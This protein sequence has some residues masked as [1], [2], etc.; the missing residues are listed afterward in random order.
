MGSND[1]QPQAAGDDRNVFHANCHQFRAAQCAD[2]AKQQQRTVAPA[3]GGVVAGGENLAQHRQGERRGLAHGATAGAH[4][5][6]QRSL[7]VAVRRVPCQVV[8][9]VHFPQGR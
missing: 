7:D 8:E 3:A 5:P 4:H 1:A 6:L 9:P 2:E